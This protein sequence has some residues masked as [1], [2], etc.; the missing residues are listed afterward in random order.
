MSGEPTDPSTVEPVTRTRMARYAAAVGDFNPVHFDDDVAAA[1][2]LPS[3]I[4]QGPFTVALLLDAVLPPGAK[5]S[6]SV[7]ARLKTPV[8]PGEQLTAVRTDTGAELRKLDGS[9]AVVA[10][11]DAA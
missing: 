6:G 7:R 11:I 8:F 10:E 5:E 3:V 4:V 2:G 9:V 1:A